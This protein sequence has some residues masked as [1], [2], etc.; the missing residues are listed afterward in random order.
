LLFA[1]FLSLVFTSINLLPIGQLDG[2]HVLYGLVGYRRHRIIA[3]IIFFAFL[4]FAVM[5]LISP[6]EPIADLLWEIPLLIGFIYTCL[7][8]LK[9]DRKNTLLA[10]IIL[11]TVQYLLK[12]FF[13]SL[14]GYWTWM[15]FAFIIGR[16]IGIPHPPS[17]IE[18]P[19]NRGRIIL[20]CLALVIFVLCFTPDPLF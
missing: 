10:A 14:Q 17:D 7:T 19:L 18:N 8:G 2:G 13:P 20:G 4:F 12:I 11:F 16:F 6:A 1:G 5:G 3:T 15:P 9:W